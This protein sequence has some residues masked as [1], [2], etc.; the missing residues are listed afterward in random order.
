LQTVKR[1]KRYKGSAIYAR[2]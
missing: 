2:Y 1:F